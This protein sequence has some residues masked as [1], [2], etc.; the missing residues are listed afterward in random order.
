MT[1][2]PLPVVTELSEPYWSGL[3]GGELRFQRCDLCKNAWLPARE[4][5]PRCLSGQWR[6]KPS[7]GFGRIISWVIY[8]QSMHPAFADRVP[9]N[10]AIVELDEGPRL[11]TNIDAD[12]HELAIERRVRLS[13]SSRPGITLARFALVR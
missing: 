10:V 2:V 12:E 5:C 8:R 7:A 13:I 6:W 3:A 4:Q 11:I 9:Y 1:E